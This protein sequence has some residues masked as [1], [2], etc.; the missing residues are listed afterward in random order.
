MPLDDE[1]RQAL[2]DAYVAGGTVQ[3]IAEEHGVSAST[4]VWSARMAGV[5]MRGRKLHKKPCLLTEEMV[6]Q[7]K[8]LYL[9]GMPWKLILREVGDVCSVRTYRTHVWAAVKADRRAAG[10]TTALS[11][12][13]TQRVIPKPVDPRPRLSLPLS[14]S[15]ALFPVIE[16]EPWS[17]R[18]AML[19]ASLAAEIHGTDKAVRMAAF[20]AL[21][22]VHEEAYGGISLL[23]NCSSPLKLLEIFL[24][25]P[26]V[27]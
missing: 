24:N 12:V 7:A 22:R 23:I 19:S 20:R 8:A 21:P 26:E 11:R 25:D 9:T 3:S 2:V 5:K 16:V 18:E 1:K 10:Q 6:Q 17:L 4:V 13:P 14:V 15:K 27:I